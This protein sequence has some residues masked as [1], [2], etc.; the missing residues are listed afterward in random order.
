MKKICVKKSKICG[1]G[2]FAKEAINSGTKIGIF[3]GKIIS[4]TKNNLKKYSDYLLSISYT[5]AI[6]V[7]ND[8]KF[9]NH[10]CDPNCGVKDGI[11]LTAIKNIKKGEELTLDYS[12]IT[13]DYKMKCFC[14]NKICRGETRGYKCL[15]KKLKKKYLGFISPFLLKKPK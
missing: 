14:K 9:T 4:E 10:S 8:L 11:I 2:I 5:K 7:K 12:T 13:Y 6:L 1:R 15:N 3:K